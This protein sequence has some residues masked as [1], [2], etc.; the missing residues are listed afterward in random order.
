MRV[1]FEYFS[2]PIKI[3]GKILL[4]VIE[5]K[6]L[7]RKT[8][9]NLANEN[10]EGLFVFSKDYEP[11]EYSKKI[12]CVTNILICDFADKTL[13]TKLNQML[14]S[15]AN[16]RYFTE[17]S[18][19]KALL[20]AFS[21][22]L[23]EETNFDFTCNPDVETARLF[24]LFGFVPRIDNDNEIEQLL[25]YFKLMRDY[26]GIEC[27]VTQNLHLLLTNE[28]LSFLYQT[29]VVENIHLIDIES[30]V[31]DFVDEYEIKIIIDN[32]L[33]EMIK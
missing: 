7:Y 19:L 27:F 18:E 8:I 15:I 28:E 22:K 30:F 33:C 6:Q 21:E 16:T 9:L 1:F 25:R 5:N 31:P 12:K 10:S 14:E 17:T 32:D 3:N 20:S 11:L 2:E 26:L 23:C 29:L 24:K 4:L 13:I